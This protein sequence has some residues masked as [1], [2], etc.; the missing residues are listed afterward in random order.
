MRHAKLIRNILLKNYKYYILINNKI[1]NYDLETDYNN[2]KIIERRHYSNQLYEFWTLGGRYTTYS[3]YYK[4]RFR[5]YCTFISNLDGFS[6]AIIVGNYNVGNLTDNDIRTNTGMLLFLYENNGYYSFRE[7]HISYNNYSNSKNYSFEI[8]DN[9]VIILTSLHSFMDNNFKNYFK[10]R[11]KYHEDKLILYNYS[12]YEYIYKYPYIKEYNLEMIKFIYMKNKLILRN[13]NKNE[14][15]NDEKY[16]IVYINE[17][18]VDLKNLY[19]AVLRRSFF[20]IITTISDCQGDL[21]DLQDIPGILKLYFLTKKEVSIF[22]NCIYEYFNGKS[23]DELKLIN[24][25][26]IFDLL[27][28]MKKE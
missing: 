18:T 5:E 22:E 19:I 3:F 24:K 16:D 20:D 7:F 13:Y 4:N 15:I 17:D 1:Y 9:G 25:E 2:Q 11:Y 21:K 6:D 14:N 26:I 27:K 28:E 23:E 8:N 10:I 12:E